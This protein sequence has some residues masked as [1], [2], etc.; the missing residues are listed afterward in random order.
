[1]QRPT[2]TN[3]SIK[4]AELPYVQAVNPTVGGKFSREHAERVWSSAETF[5]VADQDV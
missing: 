4:L 2:S 3:I 5:A 1:M